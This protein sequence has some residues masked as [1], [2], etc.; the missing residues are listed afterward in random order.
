MLCTAA[1]TTIRSVPGLSVKGGFGP[2]ALPLLPSQAQALLE[3]FEQSPF[4]KGQATLL[5][6]RVR[7]SWQLAP[8]NF[9][10]SNPDWDSGLQACVQR[11]QRELCCKEVRHNSQGGRCLAG[12][13]CR[14][15]AGFTG[16][17]PPLCH[18][19]AICH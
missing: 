2:V 14:L 17:P 11:V 19:C 12:A 5:D 13:A 16:R 15:R 1:A 9:K 8:D 7:K 18:R 3:V 6:D 4:G 10:L